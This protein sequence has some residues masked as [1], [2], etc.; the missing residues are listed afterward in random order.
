MKRRFAAAACA[1]ALL[2]P[3]AAGAHAFLDHASPPVGSTARAPPG[4]VKL[5]FT[6]E[7]EPAFSSVTVQDASGKRVDKGDAKIAGDTMQVSLPRLPAGRYKVTWRA[8]SRD[9]H[10]TDGDFTFEVAP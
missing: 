1:L 6:Q 9:T 7:L 8:L 5:W 4:E 2:C 10:V 3:L